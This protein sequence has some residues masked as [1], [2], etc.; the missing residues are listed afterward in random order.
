[1]NSIQ[2]APPDYLDIAFKTA[3]IFIALFNLIFAVTIFKVKNKKDQTDK[4]SDRKIQ[5]LKSLILDHNLKY[6]YSFFES[7]EGELEHLKNANLS[8]E[9][10]QV[11]D[12]NVADEFIF[13]R[14][15]FTD[16]LL[17]IDRNLYDKILKSADD[18][19]GEIT[20]TIFDPGIKLS[21]PPKFQESLT[22]KLTIFKTDVLE[23]LFQYR[24]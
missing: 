1:M 18:L 4:E 3:T 24:G 16:S 20:T 10:K 11:I 7:L 2:E 6:F 21:H 8:D 17:A 15:K 12:E 9:N 13:L 19:Q 23:T 5:W 22:E 14:R